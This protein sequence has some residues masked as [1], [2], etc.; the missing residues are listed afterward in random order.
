MPTV[1][2]AV[3]A[4]AAIAASAFACAPVVPAAPATSWQ[5]EGFQVYAHV[6]A[7]PVGVVYVFHG[8]GGSAEIVNRIEPTDQLNALVA[9]GYGW[10]ATEST[11]RTVDRR[12]DVA[13][14]SLV[15]NPDLARLD[16]LHD[17]LIAT[18]AVAA[19]TPMFGIGMSNGAR[20]VTLWGQV[21]ADSGHPVAAVAPFMGRAALPVRSAGGLTVPGFWVMA[22]NDSVVSNPQIVT[23]QAANAA[24][25]VASE[26]RTKNEEPLLA[27]RF[28][29]I[30]AIDETEAEAIRAALEGTGVWDEHGVRVMSIEDATPLILGL[31]LPPSFGATPAQVLNQIEA[32]LAV[33]QF[34]GLFGHE[35][36]D[37]FDDQLP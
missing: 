2:T 7:D 5:F 16:R 11:D 20:M 31:T 17:E 23:D 33:H 22:E 3:V 8:S 15:S 12:W 36:A 35:V 13:D 9:R 29:R 34:V 21:F 18:T 28:T 10:V 19:D 27:A 37:F 30:P 6:P 24:N 14:P 25:G 26:L 1:R 32:V 4:R